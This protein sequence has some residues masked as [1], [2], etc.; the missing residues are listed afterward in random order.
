M[1]PFSWDCHGIKGCAG[2]KVNDDSGGGGNT[3]LSSSYKDLTYSLIN[4][5]QGVGLG[6][7]H[8]LMT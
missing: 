8:A 3:R 4:A 1:P 7:G 2:V 5:W 6:R